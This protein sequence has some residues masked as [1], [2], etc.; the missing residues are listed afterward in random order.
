MNSAIF[1]FQDELND[2]LIP[3]RKNAA[4]D[5]PFSQNP[6]VKHLIEALG[7]PHTEVSTVRVN[8]EPVLLNYRVQHGDRIEVIPASQPDGE[9]P[10]TE[11]RFLL[12]NHLGQLATYLR[13]LGFDTLYRNDYQDDELAQVTA[14]EGR[15][16]LTR[17]RRL[18]MR[19][20]VVHGYCIR[21]LD[22]RQ[23]VLE[24]LHRFDLFDKIAP[25]QRCLRCNHPLQPVSKESVL[26]RLEPLTKR[27]YEEFHLCPA[28][29]QVYW[30]GS[31]Y[32]RMRDLIEAVTREGIHGRK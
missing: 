25:F 6:S 3:A 9:E 23:Q 5:Y 22:P 27:Y 20:A 24:V 29:D 10:E 14:Q 4:F 17:D 16:L 31:H 2:F 11:P 15:I 13:M 32:E 7:V 8:G 30:K 26:S 18:L 21:N 28:C 19:K 12:D 1:H